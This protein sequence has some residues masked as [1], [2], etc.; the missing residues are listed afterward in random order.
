MSELLFVYG[1]LQKPDVQRKIVGRELYGE[2]DICEDHTTHD[3]TFSEGTYLILVEAKGKEVRGLVLNILSDDFF[4][5]DEYESD[6][7][8][9]VKIKLKS[10]KKAWVYKK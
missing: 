5:L 8:K 9:R 7:Y 3:I 2:E 6:V 4:A 1:T 10:G